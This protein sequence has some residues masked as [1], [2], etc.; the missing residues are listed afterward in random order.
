MKIIVFF[1]AIALAF[2]ISSCNGTNDPNPDQ[3]FLL[4]KDSTYYP[5]SSASSTE[6]RLFAYN[7]N[8]KLVRVQYRWGTNTYFGQR[9]TIIYNANGQVSMVL[10]HYFQPTAIILLQAN[11]YSYTNGILTSVNEVSTNPN[12][13]YDRT[14]TFT[15]TNEKLSAQTVVYASG[16]PVDDGPGDLTNIVFVGNN[17]STGVLDGKDPVTVTVDL[18]A[19][20][21]Y[22]GLNFDSKDFIN[23]FCQ[24]NILKAYKT[25]TPLSLLENCSYTYSNGR[26]ASI[27][28]IKDV[29]SDES[30]SILTYGGF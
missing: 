15:Y 14:R 18:T 16:T 2:A 1:W 3:T 13:S 22:Y 8:K 30:V 12:Q 25:N 21:P 27:S 19:P 5:L 26:V 9:D 11:T 23:M 28:H 17:V 7:S 10:T 20:N 24:N 29:N 4:V 6:V